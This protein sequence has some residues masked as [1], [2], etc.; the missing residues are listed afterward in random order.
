MCHKIDSPNLTL[1]VYYRTGG[2]Y[3]Y[4]IF[5]VVS[6]HGRPQASIAAIFRQ[7]AGYVSVSIPMCILRVNGGDLPAILCSNCCPRSLIVMHDYLAL[8]IKICRFFQ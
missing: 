1:V 5:L 2:L 7:S 6:I 4:L 3:V 8:S